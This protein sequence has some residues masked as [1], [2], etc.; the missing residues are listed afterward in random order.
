MRKIDY[1]MHT[2]FSSDSQAN[3]REH[4]KQAIKMGFDEICFTDHKDF[5]YPFCPFDLD[6]ERYFEE[7]KVLQDEYQDQIRIK[8]GVEMGLDVEYMNEIQDFVDAHDYDYVIGS[9]HVIHQKEFFDPA[10]FF[11]GKTK[12]EAHREFF[13]NTLE[14]VQKFDCFNCLGHLDYICRYG[15]Y[16]DKHVEHSFYQDIIDEILK[17]LIQKGKGIEVNTSG[18][19]DLKTCGFP[20]FDIVQRYYDLGGR[21]ITVGTDS[22]TSDRVGEHVEDVISHYQRIGFEDVSTFTKRVRD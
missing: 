1:H 12:E 16:D 2:Y 7:L 15:P 11:K 13:S 6:A 18:Y 21:I 3:P 5:H 9:I 4:I 19:R 17:T 8:I 10:D 20:N 14:C 22:H